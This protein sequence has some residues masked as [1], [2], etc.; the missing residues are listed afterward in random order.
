MRSV[1][2]PVVSGSVKQIFGEAGLSFN[3]RSR[4][5]S[6]ET[7]KRELTFLREAGFLGAWR[8]SRGDS[9]D[10]LDDTYRL[11]APHG[12]AERAG[13]DLPAGAGPAMVSA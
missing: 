13:A 1:S 3:E 5:R 12:P 7:F 6:I 10:A 9:R 11:E 8:M 2:G 4:Y